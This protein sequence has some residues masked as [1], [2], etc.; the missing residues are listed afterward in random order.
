M[1]VPR[2]AGVEPIAATRALAAARTAW[3]PIR[4]LLIVAGL[5]LSS[6][7][8]VQ[9]AT[10]PSP[11]LAGELLIGGS[12]SALGTMRR[13]AAEFEK[14][15][16][17]VRVKVIPSLGG[18]GGI[19]ALMAGK[20][21]LGVSSRDLDDAQRARGLVSREIA[22][23]PFVFAVAPNTP[24]TDLTLDELAALFSG[25]TPT[26]ADGTLVRPV[27][28]PPY[29]IDTLMVRNMSPALDKAIQAAHLRPGRN[30]AITDADSADDVESI[31][32]AIGTSSLALILSESRNL[33]AISVGGIAP[34]ADNVQRGLYPYKKPLFLITQAIR[35]ELTSAF[36]RFIDSAEGAS[37]LQSTG[38]I[39]IGPP[40]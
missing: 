18:T 32:G 20:L 13:L 23:S 29:D 19:Q 25:R 34:T 21:T 38:S 22:T 17:D 37:I 7:G 8:P 2:P 1:T 36:I 14:K 3:S 24:V 35:S 27:L 26:W 6:T 33:K 5:A 15:R 9:S 40:R 12:G 39:P 10:P 30:I 31:G 11:D 16:P 4:W 28:H